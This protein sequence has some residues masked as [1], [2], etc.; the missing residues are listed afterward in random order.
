MHLTKYWKAIMT[1]EKAL[2]I[3][4]TKGFGSGRTEISAFDAALRK[5]GVHNYNLIA[6]SS[7]IPAHSKVIS[8]EPSVH[9]Y[10]ADEH[11]K[12]LYVVMAK[13][14]QNEP[15]LSAYAGVGWVQSDNKTDPTHAGRGLFVE[16][17]GLSKEDVETKIEQSL[18]DMVK[19][20]YE[21]EIYGAQHMV[22]HGGKVKT[23]YGCS[24]VVA[25]YQSQPWA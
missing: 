25:V 16:H 21:G 12:R 7:V 24:V 22:V 20:R 4:I 3:I 2:K 15:G 19:S 23:G 10:T 11:G 13:K 8:S 5:A 18:E 9:H 17:N 14:L 6:L 1:K